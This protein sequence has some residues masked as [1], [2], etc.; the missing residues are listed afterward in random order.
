LI[1]VNLIPGGKKRGGRGPRL[2]FKLPSM[3]G[4][5][6]DRWVLGS[7]A[8]I[9][10]A[11]GLVGYLYWSSSKT[12][13]DL[14]V[15]VAAARADSARYADEISQ[16]ALLR[17]RED[18][19]LQRAT[20]IQQIDENRYV[21][22]HILDEV[23]RALPDYTWLEEVV[24]VSLGDQLQFRING[25]AGNNFAVTQF[26]E[27]LEASLFISNVDLFSTEQVAEDAGGFNRAV[28]AFSLEARF[29]QPSP[30]LLETVPLF[31]APPEGDTSSS[32]G[33]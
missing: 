31:Q 2:S 32:A 24:Q 18:S 17:A 15:D 23:A 12:Y 5:L 22:P 3:E 7:A 25:R 13:A 1:K 27:N 10:L 9:V 33:L 19:I 21:W 28:T 14:E 8:V 30:D 4:G 11:V 6:G 29:E 20:I 16:N 26:M